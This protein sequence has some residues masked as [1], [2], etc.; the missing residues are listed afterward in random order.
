GRSRRW[1]IHGCYQRHE[2]NRNRTQCGRYFVEPVEAVN[3]TQ[4]QQRHGRSEVTRHRDV[5]AV[6]TVETDI[7]KDEKHGERSDEQRFGSK[8]LISDPR[9]ERDDRDQ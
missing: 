7:E 3:E 9:G 6:P 4:T 1:W 8:R 2:S 5:S